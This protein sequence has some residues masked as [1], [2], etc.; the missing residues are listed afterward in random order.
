MSAL[1]SEKETNFHM[2]KDGGVMVLNIL[3]FSFWVGAES[4]LLSCS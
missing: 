3:V 4:K 2:H 1:V